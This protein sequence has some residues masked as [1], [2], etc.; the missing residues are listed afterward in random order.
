MKTVLLTLLLISSQAFAM[1]GKG[2]E[3][4]RGER[5]KKELNLTDEQVEKFRAMKGNRGDMKALKT[6]FKASKKAFKEAIKN[7]KVSDDELK[8]KFESFMK[9]RD[10]V[11]RA[12]F[13]RMLEKRAILTPEQ[14]EKFQEMRKN[15]KHGKGKKNKEW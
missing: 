8:T 13:A 12:K 4:Q 15:R 2:E 14:M 6:E 5:F 9:L 10:Q 11:Q 7:P 1:A 3:Q